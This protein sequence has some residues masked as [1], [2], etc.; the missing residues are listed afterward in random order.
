MALENQNGFDHNGDLYWS[1]KQGEYI[2]WYEQHNLS[3]KVSKV[4]INQSTVDQG[5][6]DSIEENPGPGRVH[7]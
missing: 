4:S 1:Q 2:G 7:D 3:S 5:V 6:D